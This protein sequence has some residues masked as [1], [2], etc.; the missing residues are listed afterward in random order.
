[1]TVSP[2]SR[3]RHLIDVNIF[4]SRSYFVEL[5]SQSF[6]YSAVNT[7]GGVLAE[8]PLGERATSAAT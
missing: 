3:W 6:W 8:F 1:M 2:G 4:K 5:N 7:L